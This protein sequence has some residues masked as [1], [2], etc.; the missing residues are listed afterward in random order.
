[1]HARGGGARQSRANVPV[2]YHRN[3]PLHSLHIMDVAR[4]EYLW[5]EVVLI[6]VAE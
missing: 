1:M 3:V 5:R 4:A 6:E 2:L